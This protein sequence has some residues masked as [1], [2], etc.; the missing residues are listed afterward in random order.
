SAILV[1]YTHF[2]HYE[3]YIPNKRITIIVRDTTIINN[4]FY[5]DSISNNNNNNNN[6]NNKSINL[7]LDIK[8]RKTKLINQQPYIKTRAQVDAKIA[9]DPNHQIEIHIPKDTNNINTIYTTT[10]NS[11]D[12]NNNNNNNDNSIKQYIYTISDTIIDDIC[13]PMAKSPL[14]FILTIANLQEP[15]NLKDAMKS[16]DWPYW[17]KA[18]LEENTALVNQH[19]WDIVDIP[20]NI[21]PISGRWVFKMKPIIKRIN[22]NNKSY[23]TNKNNTIRYKAR[24]IIQGFNQKLGIDFLETFSSTYRTETWHMLLLIAVNKGLYI[25]QYDVKNAFC[26]ANI[27]T[28]IYTILPIGLYNNKQYNN[29]CAKLN[30]A[31][32]GLKQS[33]RLW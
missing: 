22:N 9:S 23:I 3:L 31:L 32:Y 1:G 4:K 30:K 5:A 26:H 17:E 12:N 20:S 6:N 16:P 7:D 10:D 2:G 14:P 21:K 11:S 27:D 15:S 8:S 28:E 25:W 33:P 19:T 24:W 13:R 18:C 29:K